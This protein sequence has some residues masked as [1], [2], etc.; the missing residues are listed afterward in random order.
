L[1]I[2]SQNLKKIEKNIRKKKKKKKMSAQSQFASLSPSSPVRTRTPARTEDVTVTKVTETVETCPTKKAHHEH[3][4]GGYDMGHG[5]GWLGALIMWLLI[6]IVFFWLV[7]FS[8]KPTWVLKSGTQ[9]VDT[10]KVLLAAVIA[11][12]IL[13]IIIW[14]IKLAISRAY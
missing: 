11:A 4:D 2:F 10:A 14:L 5:W 9:E 1:Q 6:F 8:L 12:V 13:V 3:H 7:F